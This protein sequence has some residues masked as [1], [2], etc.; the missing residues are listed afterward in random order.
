MGSESST[1][2]DVDTSTTTGASGS[3]ETTGGEPVV[4]CSLEKPGCGPGE[5][6]MPWAADGS[7][8]PNAAR[9]SPIVKDPADEGEV[10]RVD[11]ERFSG[12][13]DCGDGLFCTELDADGMGVCRGLCPSMRACSNFET[14]CV[15]WFDG[16]LPLCS[17]ECDPFLQ[18]CAAEDACY[19]VGPCDAAACGPRAAATQQGD[20][21]ETSNECAAGMQCVDDVP[22]CASDRCCTTFCQFDDVDACAELPGTNCVPPAG[23]CAL[24]INLELGVCA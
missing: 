4:A 15:S 1:S 10:C 7:D 20:A 22:G 16:A 3:S 6:C 12:L 21:C 17:R 2:A 14:S 18:T 24:P 5:K 19:S 9:C 13:D 8:V 23:P 11:G